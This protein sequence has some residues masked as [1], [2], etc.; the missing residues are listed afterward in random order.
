MRILLV[1][2]DWIQEESIRDE[3]HVAFPGSTVESFCTELEFRENLERLRA[4]PPDLIIL[5][6]MIR[7]TDPS[8]E[9]DESP[10]Q[11][12]PHLA[13]LRCKQL[14]N[15]FCKDVPIVFHTILTIEDV[16]KE[17]GFGNEKKERFVMKT[18]NSIQ[19]IKAIHDLTHK[20]I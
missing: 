4:E 12:D 20:N 17:Q 14:L 10:V 16:N 15:E 7:W 9:L 11:F 5:D 13:G 6:M 8:P 18:G 1:E 19:L 2:D 3:I